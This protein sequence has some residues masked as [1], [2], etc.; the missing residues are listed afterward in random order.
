MGQCEV[1]DTVVIQGHEPTPEVEIIASPATASSTQA[2]VKHISCPGLEIHVP[3][4]KSPYSSYPFHLHDSELLPW[5]MSVWRGHLFATS[6]ACTGAANGFGSACGSCARLASSPVIIGIQN[7]MEGK[8]HPSTPYAYLPASDLIDALRTK[9]TQI[10]TLRL[11]GLNH[12]RQILRNSVAMSNHKRLVVA[13][14]EGSVAR[15]DRVVHAAL[16]KKR[17]VVGI[18]EQVVR[19]AQ[20]VYHV[21]GFTEREQALGKLLWRLGGDRVGHIAHRALGL[22]SVNMLRDGSPKVPITPSAGRPTV[23]TMARNTLGVLDGVLGVLKQRNANVQHA[24]LMFDELACEKHIRWNPRTNEFL[25]LCREHGPKVA[26]EFG[27]EKDVEELFKALDSGE[28]HYASEATIGALG[29]LCEDNRLYSARPILISGDCKKESGLE[30]AAVLQTVLDGV[31]EVKPTTNLRIVSIASDG[32]ACRGTALVQMTFKNELSENSNIYPLLSPLSLLNLHIGVDDLTCDKDWKHIFK[33][34]RNL[35][36]CDR[37]IVI[38]D[39]H[40]TPAIMKHLHTTTASAEHLNAV[41]N[42]ND[43][44][45]VK[46][47]FD[48]LRD[49]WSLPTLPEPS[50]DDPPPKPG[51]RRGREALQILGKLLHHIVFAYLC[52]DLTLSEQLEHL[53]AA[54]HLAFVLYKQAGSSFIPTLLYIDIIIMI[55]NIFFCVAKAK[56]D[57]PN[58]FFFI[59]LL[60]TDRIEIHFG[61]LRT[62][63]GN[64]CNLDIIQISDRAGGVVDIADILAT[65]PDWDR[66]PRRMRV[67]TLTAQSTE[68]PQSSDHLSPSYYKKENMSLKDVTLQTCWRRGRG[69]AE[70][71]YPAAVEILKKADEDGDIDMLAPNGELLVVA[72]LSVD[73]V[74]ESS[75]AILLQ[76]GPSVEPAAQAEEEQDARMDIEN[77]LEELAVGMGMDDSPASATPTS[78]KV[79]HTLMVNGKSM[80]KSKIISM[81]SQYQRTVVSGDH[82]KRVQDVERFNA[83]QPDI[84]ASYSMDSNLLLIHD[85]IATLLW[86]DKRLWLAIER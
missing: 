35:L 83:S 34:F 5:D 46:L 50:S 71:D 19:A 58:G 33:C 24:V 67:P 17:G 44:Q 49:I 86:C 37:G 69:R 42:P 65:N 32:E 53:S 8:P 11:S 36:L 23:S 60:G 30:H 47:A 70:A 77:E 62:V 82:L 74:D 1:L 6:T 27:S 12:M 9:N 2:L 52:V 22:P 80:S 48:L 57:T 56:V 4:N 54:A 13:I 40:I 73:D 41:F 16:K 14:A 72:P 59:I 78:N 76:T 51:F 63:I 79:E 10:Q 38:D 81:L 85:P 25:G 84:A 55:K 18:L 3:V 45:D 15:V 64:D 31:N 75:E 66:G 68:V 26:L 7:R 21:R 28:I 43:L 61:I 29:I 20:G 39:F